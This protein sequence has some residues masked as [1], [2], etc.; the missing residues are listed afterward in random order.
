[1]IWRPVHAQ[2]PPDREDRPSLGLKSP[3]PRLLLVGP[4]PYHGRHTSVTSG[5]CSRDTAFEHDI[6]NVLGMMMTTTTTTILLH[7]QSANNFFFGLFFHNHHTLSGESDLTYHS[8][9][10]NLDLHIPEPFF[11]ELLTLFATFV[12]S[13][14]ESTAG[15]S[16]TPAARA[17]KINMR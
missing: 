3:T 15:T 5:F 11:Y 14:L 13:S 7:P 10:D 1:M 12:Y 17:R 8:L 4:A 6:G 9:L 2:S 16:L